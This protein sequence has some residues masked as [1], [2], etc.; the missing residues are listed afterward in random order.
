MKLLIT[1][2]AIFFI[3][4]NG[5]I[6]LQVFKD[7]NSVEA[8]DKEKTT[9]KIITIT[10]EIKNHLPIRK[11]LKIKNKYYLKTINEKITLINIINTLN[12]SNVYF[13]ILAL[14]LNQDINEDYKLIL[15]PRSNA[16][17]Y[18]SRY[19]ITFQPLVNLGLNSN[20]AKQVLLLFNNQSLD[21]DQ[22]LVNL[23]KLLVTTKRKYIELMHK[24][25]AF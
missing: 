19:T 13:D 17:R 1:I 24:F 21:A 7:V 22:L 23:T 16:I 11:D 18:Y 14:D 25:I 10:V 8:G 3:G 4:S 5:L 15:V 12:I 6:V 2:L 9:A 20:D